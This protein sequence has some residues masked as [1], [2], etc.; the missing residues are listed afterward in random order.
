MPRIIP[1]TH[2]NGQKLID[3]LNYG[4]F[5]HRKNADGSKIYWICERKTACRAR[6][7]TEEKDGEIRI[8]KSVGEHDH[9]ATAAS[10]KARESLAQR[11][12]LAKSEGARHAGV[13]ALLDRWHGQW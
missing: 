12:S 8:I 1:S 3:D 4:Y 6:V 7:H 10:V 9:P 2:R 5:R 13:D 11:E